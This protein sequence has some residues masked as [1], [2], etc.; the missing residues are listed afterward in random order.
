[1]N[2]INADLRGIQTAYEYALQGSNEGGIPIGAVLIFDD[3]KESIHLGGGKNERIQKGS[4]TMHGEISALESA[5]R[6][7]ADVYKRCTMV[8]PS[9]Q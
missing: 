1:M 5:G 3:G 7:A 6:Q 2:P 9:V 8:S 4:P